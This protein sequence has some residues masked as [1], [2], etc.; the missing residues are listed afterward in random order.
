MARLLPVV[1]EQTHVRAVLLAGAGPVCPARELAGGDLRL[2]GAVGA[3]QA[4][5][6]PGREGAVLEEHRVARESP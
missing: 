1:A 5:V 3:H 2:A 6:L 4:H